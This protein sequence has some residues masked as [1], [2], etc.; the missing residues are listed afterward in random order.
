MARGLK[1][2]HERS[3]GTLVDQEVSTT[4]SSIGGTGG[5]P[6]WITVQGVKTVKVQF[7]TDASIYHGNAY[8]VAQKG[9]RQFLVANAVG[10]TERA[11]HSNASVTVATLTAGADAANAA[12]ATGAGAMTVVGYNTSGTPF[13][14]KRI[15]NKYVWDFSDN[16][17]RWRT[18]DNAATATFANVICH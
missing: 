7:N 6:Q 1:I 16:R 15:S 11:T 5:R 18:S 3:D 2:S 10:A 17:Y 8:V 12:P 9:A 13:Y 14:V 4:I